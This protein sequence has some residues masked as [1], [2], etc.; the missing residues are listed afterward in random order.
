MLRHT[1]VDTGNRFNDRAAR[2][3]KGKDVKFLQVFLDGFLYAN[4]GQAQQRLLGANA[5]S[6]GLKL[7]RRT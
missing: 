4:A 2:L 7:K 5:D 1:F 3:L 6:T